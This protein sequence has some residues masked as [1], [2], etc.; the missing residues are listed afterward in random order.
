MNASSA[1][2][3]IKEEKDYHEPIEDRDDHQQGLILCTNL[4]KGSWMHEQ[5]GQAS[6]RPGEWATMR[7]GDQ[8]RE[9]KVQ[10]W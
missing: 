4:W 7:V 5:I 10:F 9:Q 2:V 3:L 1:L 8:A 6:G